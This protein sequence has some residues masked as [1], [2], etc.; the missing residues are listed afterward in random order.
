MPVVAACTL[1]DARA[2]VVSASSVPRKTEEMNGKP[3]TRSAFP[4]SVTPP[5][6]DIYRHQILR[7]IFSKIF[8]ASINQKI[9]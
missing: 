2:C 9:D 5:C 4:F 1:R 6:P 8:L 3:P 7:Q